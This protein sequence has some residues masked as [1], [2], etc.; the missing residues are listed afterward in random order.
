MAPGK[1]ES[2]ED[3]GSKLESSGSKPVHKWPIRPGVHVHVNGLH[4]L[5]GIAAV[6]GGGNVAPTD[7]SGFSFGAKNSTGSSGSDSSPNQ[8]GNSDSESKDDSGVDKVAK[9]TSTDTKEEERKDSQPVNGSNASSPNTEDTTKSASES[10]GSLIVSFWKFAF[11][12][13]LKLDCKLE[14]RIF[15]RII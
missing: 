15:L 5:G 6:S 3:A 13:I 14:C 1:T 12:H 4:A 2:A 11:S 7:I 9:G 10:K 8:T